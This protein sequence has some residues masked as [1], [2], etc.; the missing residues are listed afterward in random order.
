MNK[1]ILKPSFKTRVLNFFRTFF[2]TPRMERIII[3]KIAAAESGTIW[4]KFVPPNYLYAKKSM[5]ETTRNN[6]RYILDISNVV[7]HF[8]YFGFTEKVFD[9]VTQDIKQAKIIFDIGANIGTT[10]MFFSSIN[11]KAGIYAFEPH[12]NTYQR[13]EDNLKINSF[14]NIS[15]VKLGFGNK[16]DSVKLYEV[17]SNNPGMNRIIPDNNDFPYVTIE[18][19][20]LDNFVDQQGIKSVDFIKIDV[21]GFE[22]NV[23][24]GAQKTLREHLPALF[25][26]L[27]DNNLRDNNSSA[28]ALVSL[29]SSYGYKSFYRADLNIPVTI[30]SDFSSCHYDI[31]VRK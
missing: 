5:R 16:R 9:S 13:A 25:I 19:D 29:L 22:F 15:L 30:E 10:A 31:I 7:D 28:S 2:T 14:K 21:E 18:I 6:I 23:L 1:Y 20:T 27:D 26:E 12:P 11:E 24:S 17:N 3:R 8:I 4:T